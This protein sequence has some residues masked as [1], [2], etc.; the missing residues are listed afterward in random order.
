[1]RSFLLLEVA[2]CDP[3]KLALS[4]PWEEAGKKLRQLLEWIPWMRFEKIWLTIASSFVKLISQGW[5]FQ[6]LHV[7]INVCYGQTFCSSHPNTWIVR[8][9]CDF[10]FPEVDNSSP[11][12]SSCLENS[13]GRGAWWAPV[14]GVAKS[15]T[16]PAHW[17]HT[18]VEFKDFHSIKKK[19]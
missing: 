7:L 15:W 2:L 5:E 10:R 13:T 1:M 18:H 17:A 6:L 3:G 12:Q 8:S 14:H 19:F 11:L 9:L 16:R 4:W